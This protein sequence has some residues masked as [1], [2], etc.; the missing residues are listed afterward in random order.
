MSVTT[1]F[2]S[3]KVIAPLA[4]AVVLGLLSPAKATETIK[5]TAIDGYSPKSLWVKEFINFF[6]PEID[7]GLAGGHD[8]V[9]LGQGPAS[10]D[11]LFD[12]FRHHQPGDGIEDG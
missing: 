10:N 2:R 11:R 5:L 8:R 12:A 9:P 3:A 1:R 4:A 6:I 7:R